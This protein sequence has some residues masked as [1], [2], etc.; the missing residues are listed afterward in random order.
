MQ[1]T[2]LFADNEPG[3]RQFCKQEL[4]A[5]GYHV[6]LA[7]DGEDAVD[8]V[9]TMVVDLAILDEHMPRCDGLEAARHIKRWYPRLPV[10]LF[11]TDQHYESYR[12]PLMDA[13]IMKTEDLTSLQ[14]AAFW[15]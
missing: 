10:I 8:V 14:A 3:I 2:I 6:V 9:D 1:Q 11:T 5:E 12:G 7:E 15:V 13:V 4:E